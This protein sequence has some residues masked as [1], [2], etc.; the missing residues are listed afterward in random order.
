MPNLFQGAPL[1]TVTTTLTGQQNAP[2][3]Y[4]DYLSSLAS[5]AQGQLG[6]TGD[7]LVAGLTPLQ[8]QT[9]GQAAGLSQAGAPAFGTAQGALGSLATGIGQQDISQFY[10]PYQSAVMDEMARRSQL[11]VQRNLIPQMK[12]AFVGSGGLG[13]QRYAT[14][15]GQALGDVASTLSGQQAALAQ[16]GYQSALDAA[17]K[18]KGLMGTAAQIGGQLGTQQEAALQNALMAQS[19]LGAQQQ[20]IEQAKINA[21]LQNIT[22]VARVLS[23]LSIPMGQT[24]TTTGPGQQGQ[25]GLSPLAQLG[26]LG[27]FLGSAN[28]GEISSRLGGLFDWLKN[29]YSTFAPVENIPGLGPSTDYPG[30]QYPV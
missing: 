21:P 25:F 11:N 4:T 1:P 26:S 8:Q 18:Q 30:G 15:T 19:Q 16:S 2:Q 5:A 27:A 13:G 29:N 22:N 10:N 3:F 7:Q 24:Q 12:A 20:Q 17:M 9:F 6:R 14:A 23:G 28:A